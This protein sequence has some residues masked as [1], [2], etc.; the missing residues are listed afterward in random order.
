MPFFFVFSLTELSKWYSLLHG[1]SV[2]LY[3]GPMVCL[4]TGSVQRADRFGLQAWYD[5]SFPGRCHHQRL[6]L[7]LE[8]FLLLLL[9]LLL[10]LHQ[11]DRA[12]R[13]GQE[14]EDREGPQGMQPSLIWSNAHNPKMFS[15]WE[16]RCFIHGTGPLHLGAC[17]C[18]HI[19]WNP[20]LPGTYLVESLFIDIFQYRA[21]LLRCATLISGP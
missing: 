20:S 4:F 3:L 14:V 17:Q 13:A 19:P 8:L 1:L 21:S 11:G 12:G 9:L 2:N 10:Y 16:M 5:P 6:L 15:H 7:F 18:R